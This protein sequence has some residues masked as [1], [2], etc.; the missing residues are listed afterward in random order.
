MALS[1][2]VVEPF[3]GPVTPSHAYWGLVEVE[4]GMMVL[5]G[6]GGSGAEL[7][8]RYRGAVSEQE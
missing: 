6:W 1:G 4:S 5:R 3:G 8:S 2:K 7:T